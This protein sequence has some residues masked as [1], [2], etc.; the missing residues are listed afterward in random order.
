MQIKHII[1]QSKKFKNKIEPN[2]LI[3]N[4]LPDKKPL[5]SYVIC[6]MLTSMDGKVTGKFLE[7]KKLSI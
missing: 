6:H 7:D 2:D 4:Y 3:I 5:R 1:I